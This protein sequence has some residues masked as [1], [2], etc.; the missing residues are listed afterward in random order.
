MS[1]PFKK[2]A[3]FGATSGIGRALVERFIEHNIFVVAIGRREERLAELVHKYGHDKVQASPFDLTKLESIPNFVINI[4]STHPDLDLVFLNSGVQYGHD[5]TKP[6]SVSLDKIQEEFN[7]NYISQVAVTKA[8]LPFL[9]SRAK[10]GHNAGLLYTSSGLAMV[11]IPTVPNYCATKAALHSFIL[12]LRL[13]LQDTAVKVIELFPPAV[14]TELH[15]EGGKDVG[16]PLQD[17]TN[18]AWQSLSQ[19]KD[20]VPVGM[21]HYAFDAFEMKRQELFKQM[22]EKLRQAPSVTKKY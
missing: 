14:Q 7:L 10:E 12:T 20:Q 17:F 1:F 18:E 21:A 5:F 8:F 19:G 3:V 11:P 16:M 2:V 13:Q 15:G 4:T 9:L 6:E 22:A